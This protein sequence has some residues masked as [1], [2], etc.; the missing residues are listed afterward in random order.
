M[1]KTTRREQR[2]ELEATHVVRP[3]V[4]LPGASLA[5]IAEYY[6]AVRVIVTEC[7]RAMMERDQLAAEAWRANRDLDAEAASMNAHLKLASEPP[8]PRGFYV[9]GIHPEKK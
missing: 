5:E 1:K 2:A 6:P 7:A 8:E 3:R 4:P 9:T